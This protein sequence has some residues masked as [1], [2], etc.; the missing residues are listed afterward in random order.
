MYKEFL[1]EEP[2][3][4]NPYEMIERGIS[5]YGDEHWKSMDDAE[6]EMHYGIPK[7][8]FLHNYSI[9]YSF[10]TRE[11]VDFADDY[12]PLNMEEFM[13]EFKETAESHRNAP[14]IVQEN[15]GGP[16]AGENKAQ[17]GQAPPAKNTPAPQSTSAS[18]KAG[19][20][21]EQTQHPPKSQKQRQ[22]TTGGCKKG[23][24]RF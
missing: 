20:K 10:Y 22:P 15:S 13:K 4:E 9:E 18:P 5:L 2:E 8:E 1:Y 12:S 21:K 7:R 23:V 24:Q 17:K 11:K 19:K 3:S 6:F 14:K 16:P